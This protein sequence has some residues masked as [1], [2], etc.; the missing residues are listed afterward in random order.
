MEICNT[1]R[2]APSPSPPSFLSSLK[3]YNGTFSDESVWK[4]FL[5]P[6]PFLLS[7][8]VRMHAVSFAYRAY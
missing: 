5:R 4:T 2:S 1:D 7:P 6:F 8:V 3:V